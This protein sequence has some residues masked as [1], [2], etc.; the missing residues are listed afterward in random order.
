MK[1]IV[2]HPPMYPVNH[3]FYNLLG[4]YTDLIVYQ[5]GEHPVHHTKW[6]SVKI[7]QGK[8]YYKLKIFGKGAVSFTSLLN[9]SFV[10]GIVRERPDMVLSIAFWMPSFYVSVLKAFLSYKIIILTNMISATETHVSKSKQIL[11]K[12]I[13]NQTDAFISASELTTEYLSLHFLKTEIYLSLQTINV[14]IWN[15]NFN[16]LSNKNELVKKL[17]IPIGKKIMLGVGNYIEKK[18][19]K[20]VL[21]V[22][23]N[24]DQVFFLLIGSGEQENE[25][26]KIIQELRIENKV[27]II[28]R[29]EGRALLEYFK[30]SD[31]LIFPSHYDQFGFVVPEAMCSGLP[32]I[33]TTNAGASTL[34][35][36]GLNGCFINSVD[37]M[38]KAIKYTVLNLD[39][40]KNNAY[41]TMLNHTL[42]TR[43]EEFVSIFKDVSEK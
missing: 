6:I 24:I 8:V 42:E 16:Q 32:V 37:D 14:K 28:G 38:A 11:R 20:S 25:Y 4:R 13:G 19:W 23:Q 2:L 33:C 17:N 31:F 43:V 15:E 34:I 5:F 36:D 18:N 29:K 1:I 40:M 3:E 39:D 12:F 9:P 7:R 26:I 35:K 21:Q 22:M 30:I 27:S 10:V 41:N